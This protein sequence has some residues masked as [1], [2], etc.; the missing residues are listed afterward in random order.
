MGCLLPSP[1][2]Q[3][4]M[5]SHSSPGFVS[6]SE[7]SLRHCLRLPGKAV[8]LLT[9]AAEETLRQSNDRNHFYMKRRGFC[10]IALAEG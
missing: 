3:T 6:C 10:R 9:G 5:C 2:E 1:R 7:P 4:E 8:L